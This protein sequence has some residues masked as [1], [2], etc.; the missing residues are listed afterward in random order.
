MHPGGYRAMRKYVLLLL[1]IPIQTL[2]ASGLDEMILWRCQSPIIPEGRYSLSTNQIFKPGLKAVFLYSNPYRIN[3]LGWNY[4]GLKYGSG[5]WGFI[6]SFRSYSYS[7]LYNDYRTSLKLAAN[8]YEECGFSIALD[9]EDERF[10]PDD[11]YSGL[12][13]DLGFS[14]SWD[15]MSGELALKK[16]NIKKP[17]NY[18][19]RI[20]PQVIGAIELGDGMIFSAG[21]KELY[22]KEARWFF[23]QDIGITAGANLDLGYMNN[24]NILQWGLDLSWKSLNFSFVYLVVGRLNDTITMGLSWEH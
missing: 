6:G 9:Y 1:F 22:N 5:R 15:K 20:E 4:A 10:G 21:Y 8:P 13:L 7:D 19:Q 18:P 11:R 12:G 2:L 16:I 3:S 14:Y 23:R 24:P 17:Y